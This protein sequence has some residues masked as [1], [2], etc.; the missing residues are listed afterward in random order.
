M[1]LADALWR[2]TPEGDTADES[3]W[4][5]ALDDVRNDVA[6]GFERLFALLPVGHQK[7][8]RAIAADGRVYGR[9]AE[10]VELS[11][12]TAAAAVESLVGG[13]HVARNGD[14]LTIIDPL[15]A[16]W[17]RRRFPLPT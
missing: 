5:L 14:R 17:I 1:H 8:L 2:F 9:V 10:V 13:G 11:S 12:G 16:D 6:G 3:T 15:Y 7:A 4:S